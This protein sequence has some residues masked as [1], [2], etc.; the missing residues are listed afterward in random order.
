MGG[1]GGMTMTDKIKLNLNYL[2]PEIS[3]LML[4]RYVHEVEHRLA[5][6]IL[7]MKDMEAKFEETINFERLHVVNQGCGF[8]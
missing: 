6:D 1:T 8:C 3:S 4:V 5:M 7:N 2:C